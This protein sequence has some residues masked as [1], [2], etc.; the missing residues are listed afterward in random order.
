MQLTVKNI[1]GSSF[2][3]TFTDT[4]TVEQLKQEVANR[5]EGVNAADLVLVYSGQP[6]ENANMTLVSAGIEDKS[7]VFPI[8][9]LRGGCL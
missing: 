7:T 9:R 3:V 5:Q 6:L 4:T 2:K 1:N 8:Y